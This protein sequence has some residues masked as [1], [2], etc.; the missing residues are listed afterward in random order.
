[1]FVQF[2]YILRDRGVPVKPTSFL[3]LQKAL[4]LGLVTSLDDFYTVARAILV[5]S[6]R[7]F[8]LYDQVFLHHFRGVDLKDPETYELTDIAKA[9]LQEWLKDPEGVAVALGVAGKKLKEM[10]PDELIQYFLDRLREQKEAH[11]GGD[12]WIGTG[13][14]SPVGHSGTH[15]GGMRVGGI[16][17]S[18][19][20]IK[21]AM[22]RRYRDYSQD[23]PLTQSQMGEALKRLRRMVPAGP[24]DLVNVDKT[25]R[26]TLRNAGEIEIIFDRRLTDRLKVILMI[27]NGG[28]SMEPYVEIVQTLFN[29]ARSQFKDLRTYFFHNT[30]YDVVWQDAR[31]YY[32][33]ERLEDF[34]LRDPETRLILVGDA[35][36]SPYE[37]MYS[38]GALDISQ[39]NTQPSI[40]RLKF[41]AGLFRHAVWLNPAPFWRWTGGSTIGIIR[42]IF[43]MFGLTLDGLEAAVRRLA[44]KN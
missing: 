23:G 29:Y 4:S 22:D 8:D 37:L 11:H 40:D 35:S 28:W 32:R 2:F 14:T 16:S 20:A 3:R 13:G 19:S 9:L 1:M 34:A 5:K 30:I 17:R 10:T 43:P 7:Y 26:E 21:V 27:D 41:L 15:P 44:A 6:E 25:I 31:R 38:G 39:R 33:P 12:R 18:K 36:M 24:K 42:Q